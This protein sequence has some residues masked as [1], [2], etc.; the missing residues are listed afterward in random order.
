MRNL[1]TARA[2]AMAGK[3]N[4]RQ[5]RHDFSEFKRM[6]SSPGPKPVRPTTKV[7]TGQKS[8]FGK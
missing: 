6:L 2:I 1:V 4:K 7:A 5:E 8:L 3:L